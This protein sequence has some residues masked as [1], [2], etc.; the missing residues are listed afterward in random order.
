MV[1]AQTQNIERTC[2]VKWKNG[3]SQ[4]HKNIHA[5]NYSN[6]LLRLWRRDGPC[7]LGGLFDGGLGERRQVLQRRPLHSTLPLL[8]CTAWY[9]LFQ[10][11]VLLVG[12]QLLL[13]SAERLSSGHVTVYSRVLCWHV[14]VVF[15]CRY[16]Y[17]HVKYA[18]K[19]SCK[20]NCKCSS[21]TSFIQG[22]LY[23]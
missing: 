6:D 15:G 17:I 4:Y 20:S 13:L 8:R 2:T 23:G 21:Y 19:Y 9:C 3:D 11:H 22:K 18:Y 5:H 10:R 12:K 14:W 7:D 16:L 1:D